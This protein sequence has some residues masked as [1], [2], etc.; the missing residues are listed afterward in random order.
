M[1]KKQLVVRTLIA[2]SILG[3]SFEPNELIKGDE[4]IL[5]PLEEAG[6]VSSNKADI[7]YCEKTLELEPIDLAKLTKVASNEDPDKSEDSDPD[8]SED[9]DP[10]KSEDSDPDNTT[11]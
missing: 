4:S 6:L 7:A 9:S 5:K 1:A 10:D 11:T 2:V 8:K 3:A